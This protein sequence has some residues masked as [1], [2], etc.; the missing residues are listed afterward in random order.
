MI[1]RYRSA[2]FDELYR[3]E[4]LCFPPRLRFSRALMRELTANP[5]GECW[6]EA[7]EDNGIKGFIVMGYEREEA[8][9][10]AYLHTLE[11]LPEHR[12][13]GIATAL[14]TQAEASARQ[15]GAAILWLHVEEGN[16]MAIR[17][18]EALG[19]ALRGREENY[20][21]DKKSALVYLKQLAVASESY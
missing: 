17:R 8:L 18:Y 10:V 6:L 1:R 21:P 13:R 4:Q 7:G 5:L 16:Q 9:L 19:F 3:V 20:Y 15:A 14:L 2:D 11:V 12:N